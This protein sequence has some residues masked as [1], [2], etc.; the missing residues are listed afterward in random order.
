MCA[1]PNFETLTRNFEVEKLNF[2]LKVQNSKLKLQKK[3]SNLLWDLYFNV[4][5]IFLIWCYLKLVYKANQKG[6]FMEDPKNFMKFQSS[7]LSFIFNFEVS[8]QSLKV[9]IEL[10]AAGVL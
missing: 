7:I 6:S 4:L 8:D 5:F 1:P 10:R 2:E 3:F 9:S